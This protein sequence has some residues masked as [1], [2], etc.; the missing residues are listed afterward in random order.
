[1]I[2]GVK[3]KMKNEK[4]AKIKI[5]IKKSPIKQDWKTL[6]KKSKMKDIGRGKNEEKRKE[7]RWD[8]DGTME[9]RQNTIDK[10]ISK[11]EDKM[12]RKR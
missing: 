6:K 4:K 11:R 2:S 12:K 7:G 8:L 9:K 5:K 3:W 1:M 10:C